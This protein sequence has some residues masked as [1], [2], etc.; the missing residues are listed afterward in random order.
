MSVL[1][2]MPR[3][4]KSEKEKEFEKAILA[5]IAE[6]GEEATLHNISKSLIE[7]NADY[8]KYRTMIS[9]VHYRLKRLEKEGRIYSVLK[10]GERSPWGKRVYYLK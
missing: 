4:G 7:K 1:Y 10:H 8:R 9:A 5:K 3:L 6:L 2:K